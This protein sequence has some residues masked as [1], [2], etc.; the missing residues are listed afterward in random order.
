MRTMEGR[1]V[2]R[3]TI[4]SV[5]LSGFGL[6]LG[7]W[8]F[9]GYQVTER[10]QRVQRD[11]TAVSARYQQA[12]E[13]LASVRTQVLVASVLLRDALLDPDANAQAEHRQAIETA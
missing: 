4:R 2:E 12:Q 9:A 8:L 3:L 10:L 1:L 13:L 5:L 11:G 6:M 7:L